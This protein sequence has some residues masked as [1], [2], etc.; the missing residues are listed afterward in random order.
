MSVILQDGAESGRSGAPK[1]APSVS[2]AVPLLN[3]EQL[4]PELL[5]R[6]ADVLRGLP[7][8]PHQMVFVDDGSTDASFALLRQAAAADDRIVAVS[9]SRNF[10]HQN[11]L[12]AALDYVSGDAVVV[13][14]A[15]LQDPPEAIP[16][17]LAELARGFDVVFATRTGRKEAWPLRLCYHVFYRLIAS[18]ADL[19]LPLD[20]GDFAAMTRRVAD[21]MKNLPE[22]HRYMRGLRSWIGFRQTGV[23]V[24]RS[25]RFAGSSKYGFWKLVRLALDGMFAFSMAPLRAAA[26]LGAATI[27]ATL[28]YVVYALY[29]KIFLHQSPPGFT[30][31]LVAV[32][33][34][35]GIQLL[36]LGVIGEY[37]GRIYE[38]TKGRPHYI[39]R[40]VARNAEQ[41][42][43]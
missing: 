17:L 22:R 7:G 41:P 34:L 28:L 12:S 20:A 19:R 21:E 42:R 16:V 36:F 6:L 29:A 18:L 23:P 3:E 24:E 4:L 39:V 9:L 11:A 38:E 35:A 8:G 27:G 25:E 43:A 31:L 37:I 2:I 14:D 1:A 30:A 33:L 10:G 26:L 32:T 13:M 40:D 15:D 5:R